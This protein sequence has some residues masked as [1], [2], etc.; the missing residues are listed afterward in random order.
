MSLKIDRIE[1]GRKMSTFNELNLSP[2]ILKSLAGLGYEKMTDVQARV[3]PEI[4]KG[5][6]VMVQSKTGSGKTAAFGT[7]I[8]E[9]IDWE[10][11]RPQA[12][13]LTPTRELAI[14]IQEEMMNIGRFKRL[15][16]ME[17]PRL[18]NRPNS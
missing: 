13:I 17:R 10:E 6:D 4:L 16:F 9:Q 12:V 7:A 18:K 5:N 3:I 14:Q 1:R 15:P 11:N 2:E 8:S